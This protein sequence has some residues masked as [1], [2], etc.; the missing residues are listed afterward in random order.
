M[1]S[2]TK[3][4]SLPRIRERLVDRR[5]DDEHLI[6]PGRRAVRGTRAYAALLFL[7]GALAPVFLAIGLW[8]ASVLPWWGMVAVLSWFGTA[9]VGAEEQLAALLNLLLLVPAAALAR[10]VAQRR[11]PP[12]TRRTRR[13]RRTRA[14]AGNSDGPNHK[15]SGP[16]PA[17]P[18]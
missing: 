13:T 4:S 15:V 16:S 1:R 9:L 8:R 11:D 14:V 6:K 10:R 2:V 3:R 7:A 18:C 17:L 5:V 12:G